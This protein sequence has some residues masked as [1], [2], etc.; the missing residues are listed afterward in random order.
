MMNFRQIKTAL[1]N[2]LGTE[3]ANRYKVIGFQR[4]TKNASETKDS[5]RLI[6]VFYSSG[7]FKGQNNGYKVHKITYRLEFTVSKACQGDMAAINR[8]GATPTE[9]KNALSAF[10]EASDL[11]DQSFDELIDIVYNILM[12]ARNYDLGMTVGTVTNRWIDLV[13]KDQ[14]VRNGALAVLTGFINLSVQTTEEVLG[15]TGTLGSEYSHDILQKGDPNN[16]A[17]V[18]QYPSN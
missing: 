2:L 14:P 11:A 6:Q 9:I 17:G 1:L 4:Q 10:S 8:E 7:D 12:D 15:D 5:N 3:A 16:N 13:Q 18:G